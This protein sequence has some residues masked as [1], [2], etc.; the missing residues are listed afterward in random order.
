MT[1]RTAQG[2]R[3]SRRLSNLERPSAQSGIVSMKHTTIE[4]WSDRDLS[5]DGETYRAHD[6]RQRRE[7]AAQVQCP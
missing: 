6:A 2:T 4:L 1:E 5:K 3:Q 7:A